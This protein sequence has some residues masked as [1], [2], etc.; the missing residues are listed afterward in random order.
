MPK[1]E[2][3]FAVKHDGKLYK[4]GETVEMTKEQADALVA[5]GTLKAPKADPVE[6]NPGMVDATVKPNNA[7]SVKVPV[8]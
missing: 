2:V 1:Y 4:P 3:I 8:Q 5:R 6:P 7:E